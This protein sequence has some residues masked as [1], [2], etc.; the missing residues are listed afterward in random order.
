MNQ[1]YY[2]PP[3]SNFN[4]VNC[5]C[6]DGYYPFNNAECTS[7]PMN[8]YWDGQQC[9]TSIGNCQSGFQWD[10]RKKKCYYPGFNC[11]QNEFW[12]GANCRCNQGFFYLQGKCSTCPAGTVFDGIQCTKGQVDSRCYDPYSYWNGDSCVCMPGYWQLGRTCVTCPQYYEWNGICCSPKRGLS[13][14]R[15]NENVRSNAVDV[16]FK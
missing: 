2:C 16:K 4:G 10:V 15:T 12:D 14:A 8:N 11:Q 9:G 3:N 6:N 1:N 7:C 5:Q 13:F